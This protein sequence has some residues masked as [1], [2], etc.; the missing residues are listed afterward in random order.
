MKADHIA[1]VG[2]HLEAIEQLKVKVEDLTKDSKRLDW[3]QFHGA[4]ICWGKDGEYCSVSRTSSEEL[5]TTELFGDW[6]EAID[7]AMNGKWKPLQ[8]TLTSFTRNELENDL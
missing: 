4:K 2:I 5:E 1:I 3:M 7:A 8:L 6:R